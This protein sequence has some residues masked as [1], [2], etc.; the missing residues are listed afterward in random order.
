M[1]KKFREFFISEDRLSSD[2]GKL[3]FFSKPGFRFQPGFW[4]EL[5]GNYKVIPDP[6]KFQGIIS[7]MNIEKAC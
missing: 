2:G 6:N 7:A 4:H 3:V 5:P 1:T